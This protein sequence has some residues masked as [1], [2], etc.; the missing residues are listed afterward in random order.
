[1]RPL[2]EKETFRYWSKNLDCGCRRG[3]TTTEVLRI[4]SR[5]LRR[6][7]SPTG[8]GAFFPHVWGN[9]RSFENFTMRALVLTP[10]PS[11]TKMSPVRSKQLRVINVSGRLQRRR[12]SQSHQGRNFQ[13]RVKLEELL[14]RASFPCPSVTQTSLLIHE[15]AVRKKLNMPSP[16][17]NS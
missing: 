9:F 12:P 10:C 16:T 1:L 14:A 4:E 11:A 5:A 17:L 7:R 3:S 15:N 13:C 8:A 2:V 6:H